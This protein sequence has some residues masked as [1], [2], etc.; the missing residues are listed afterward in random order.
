MISQ[1]SGIRASLSIGEKSLPLEVEAVSGSS[2]RVRFAESGA[3]GR[4][5]AG[6]SQ[7]LDL[8]IQ[9]DGREVEIGP[10]RLEDGP[11]GRGDPAT[12]VPLDAALDIEQLL[13]EAMAEKAR[14]VFINLSTLLSY[15]DGID[16]AFREYVSDLIYDLSIYRKLFGDYDRELIGGPERFRELA[17]EAI[18]KTEAKSF[19][20]LLDQKLDQL[21]R[22]VEGFDKAQHR[23]HGYF[24]RRQMWDFI[25]ASELIAR[26]NIKPRGYSGD[27]EMMALIYANDYRG[28]STFSKL[29]F[30]HSAEHPAS[31]AVRNRRALIADGVN[32]YRERIEPGPGE[33]I[34][35]LSVACGGA[36]EMWDIFKTPADCDE[37]EV[38]LL[39]QD[40]LALAEAARNIS[41]V[42]KKHGRS[43]KVRYLN[44]SVRTMLMDSDLKK[45]IGSY[46]FIYSMGL[47]DYLTPR[48]GRALMTRLYALLKEGGELLAGNFHTSNPS[49]HYM[50][51]WVD[52]VLY[53]RTEE[54]FRGLTEGSPARETRVY[55]EDTGSQMFLQVR[56]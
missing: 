28:E 15:K 6:L 8:K 24:F 39:D 25:T 10:C 30:K 50:E 4:N 26:G 34:R 37:L 12:L 46:D 1:S 54:E 18:L 7:P 53:Y 41:L 17:L 3:D 19:F 31:Q 20:A 9:L 48:V 55:F 11:G 51:Y 36:A 42:E 16:P 44:H 22:L 38:S 43:I 35:I 29:L 47:F 14:S 23:R 2:L 32:N 40:E 33:R 45:E 56:K 21:A 49:R 52:W 5:P 13:V 27:S